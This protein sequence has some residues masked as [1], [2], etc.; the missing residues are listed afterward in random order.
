VSDGEVSDEEED[1]VPLE[2]KGQRTP[3]PAMLT[4]AAAP[5]PNGSAVRTS[6]IADASTV[7]PMRTTQRQDSDQVFAFVCVTMLASVCI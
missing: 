5:P 3:T 2:S 1:A 4:P 6:T 7:S